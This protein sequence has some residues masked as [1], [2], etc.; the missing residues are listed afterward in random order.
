MPFRLESVQPGPD[1]ARMNPEACPGAAETCGKLPTV[2]MLIESS[3]FLIPSSTSYHV[4][5][6]D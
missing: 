2:C 1:V 6:D 5:W 4:T 3:D